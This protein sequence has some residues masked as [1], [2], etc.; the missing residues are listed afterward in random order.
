MLSKLA[1]C[2]V[3][4][5]TVLSYEVFTQIGATGS[6]THLVVDGSSSLLIDA[7]ASGDVALMT[8]FIN[9]NGVSSGQL[10][11]IFITH[12]HP[13][14]Y[15]GIAGL[16][17][18]FSTKVIVATTT[19]KNDLIANAEAVGDTFDYSIIE[20]RSSGGILS[21]LNLSVY[22][23]FVPGESSSASILYNRERNF[24]LVGDIIYADAH[25]YLGFGVDF[26]TVRDWRDENLP[27]L[28]KGGDL[29][30]DKDTVFYTGHGEVAA[31]QSNISENQDYITFFLETLFSCAGSTFPTLSD[32]A[33]D[34][35]NEYPDYSS[36]SFT[37]FLTSNTAW[38]DAQTAQ[39]DCGNYE[40]TNSDGSSDNSSGS[41]D[42]SSSSSGSFLQASVV[43]CFG[44]L[45]LQ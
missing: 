45:L 10:D 43:V 25:L 23:N 32:V 20:V 28:D 33:T 26:D 35:V 3:L 34:L 41:S 13:D 12:G 15:G 40:Y 21:D 30:F 36:A 14:H 27:K 2:L 4:V 17:N 7:G 31:D 9:N 18:N 29:K 19:I 5:C 22:T 24:A 6:N 11:A 37:S 38:T 8:S 16:L 44:L 39:G 1:I 42:N